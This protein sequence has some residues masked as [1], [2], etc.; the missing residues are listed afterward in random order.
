MNTAGLFAGIILVIAIGMAVEEL[1][2]NR[3][4]RCTIQKWGMSAQ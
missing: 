1:V 3:L 4:E 2:F